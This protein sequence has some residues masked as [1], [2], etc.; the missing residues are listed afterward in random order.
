L[1]GR[2]VIVAGVL[3]RVLGRILWRVL[4]R[5]LWG[6]GGRVI[7]R[8]GT[9]TVWRRVVSLSWIG[10]GRVAR[11]LVASVTSE[12]S[13]TA[14][15]ASYKPWRHSR[16]ASIAAPALR[17]EER[18]RQED[19]ADAEA[20]SEDA[21]HDGVVG[22]GVAGEDLALLRRLRAGGVDDYDVVIG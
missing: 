17:L 11:L 6:V 10:W 5:V 16:V 3:R 19:A 18:L 4:W 15:A 8:R 14:E 9:V 12:A 2:P 13:E 7:R 22:V 1:L 20:E 21:G